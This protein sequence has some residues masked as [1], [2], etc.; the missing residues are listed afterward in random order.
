MAALE[1]WQSRRGACVPRCAGLRSHSQPRRE[2]SGAEVTGADL[3]SL[4][5]ARPE[6]PDPGRGHRR[7]S[8]TR[9]PLPHGEPKSGAERLVDRSI[10][11]ECLSATSAVPTGAVGGASR[12]GGRGD[13]TRN[14]RPNSPYPTPKQTRHKSGREEPWPAAC[15][16]T[17]PSLCLRC[18]AQKSRGGASGPPPTP[19]HRERASM[20]ETSGQSAF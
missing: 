8:K 10:L 9:P 4:L 2:M 12:G 17:P 7:P 6:R 14:G 5:A 1:L 3:A 11:D 20:P 15:G 19:P 13:P 18:A 16:G